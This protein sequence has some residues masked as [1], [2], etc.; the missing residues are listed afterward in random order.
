MGDYV[1]PDGRRRTR[2]AARGTGHRLVVSDAGHAAVLG[3]CL[4]M[5]TRIPELVVLSYGLWQRR[6]AGDRGVIGRKVALNGRPHTVIGVMPAG[7]SF[8]ERITELWAPLV[9][10]PGMNRGYHLLNVTGR[11]K[12]TRRSKTRAPS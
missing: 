5:P 8:P 7:F 10:E 9:P 4:P 3:G 2:K 11:L 12:A 1:Q 6:F